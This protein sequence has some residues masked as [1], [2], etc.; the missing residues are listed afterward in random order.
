MQ[1][2][3]I[4]GASG[5]IGSFLVEEA[6]AN[7]YQVYAGIRN[8]SSKTYLQDIRIQL[9]NTQLGDK[10]ALTQSFV[11]FKKE[12]G[13]FDFVIHN[14]GATKVRDIQ[15][16][17]TINTAYT[18][19]LVE[20]L[21]DSKCLNGK[22]ILMSSLAAY[23]PG[24]ELTMDPILESGKPMPAGHYGRSKLNA[25]QYLASVK[26]LDYL[27]FRPT[28]VYGPRE[29]DYL[30]FFKTLLKGLEPYI[31]FKEQKNHLY[32][33]KRSSSIGCFLTR[34]FSYKKRLLCSRWKFLFIARLCSDIERKIKYQKYK[35]IY[36]I[37]NCKGFR[38]L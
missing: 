3:L 35:T 9:F 7:D 37:R 21:L 27:I 14:A 26:D 1:K 20:A 34:F 38:S 25:E 4:T 23:G 13:A 32:L 11:D 17:Y 16:F 12:Y 28:G 19:N 15:D 22:F 29:K 2:V 18:Q 6:L 36:S 33:C 31:G 5:F 8:T 10:K 30:I 24:N